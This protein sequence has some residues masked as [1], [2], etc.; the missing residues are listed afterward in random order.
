MKKTGFM[1][2]CLLLLCSCHDR[3]EGGA[4]P[5]VR[6]LE[7]AFA[8]ASDVEFAPGEQRSIPF[9]VRSTEFAG[10]EFA[11]TA[12]G[13]EASRWSLSVEQGRA[14]DASMP[15]LLK[16][17]APAEEGQTRLTVTVTAPEGLRR[18]ASIAVR[19]VSPTAPDPEPDPGPEAV[20]LSVAGR[21]NCYIIPA[22]GCY[23][24]DA[25]VRGNGVGDGASIAL[26]D[27]M[28]A[29][30]LWAT[31]GVGETLG[32]VRFDAARG[33]IYVT[34]E[35]FVA[36]NALVVL[37][38]AQG[39]VVWSWHLWF[40]EQPSTVTYANGRVM[41]DRNLGAMSATPGE[42][43]AYGLYYQW[44]RKEPFCGGV[45]TESSA[46]SMA[47]ARAGTTVNPAFAEAHA[48]QQASGAEL[49]TLGYAA[50]HPM[51]FLSNKGTTGYYD[52]LAS[53]RD[54]L[55]APQKSCYDPCPPGYRVPDRDT[56]DDFADA[57]NRYID[58]VSE[59]DGTLYGMTY[60]HGDL[61]DWYPAQ[62]YR[63][64]DRGN[65]V[66]LG[67]TRTGHYWSNYRS[68]QTISHFYVSKRLSTGK[69]LQPQSTDKSDAA[70]GYNVRCQRE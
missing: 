16:A 13:E 1:V 24:F 12:E 31:T 56:W 5:P 60:I 14:E 28:S 19:V 40:T 21:A 38:D 47:Q 59:W 64:R 44:G 70:Y 46:E 54:D 57:G 41:Q 27:D 48:W 30:W 25:T 62:G 20:E 35:P 55:W 22:A 52:W 53:P 8:D 2:S 63:N 6:Q 66:G 33:R 34:V 37:T 42:P 11:A 50:A 15:C 36:G 58:G 17:Q 69:L 32:E 51:T 23:M 68:G 3:K 9:T 65:L 29:D 10:L 49:S 7:V 39:A 61:R 45:T 26:S 4:E 18:E 67:T 43:T